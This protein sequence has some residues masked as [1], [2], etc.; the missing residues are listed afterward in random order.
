MVA[1]GLIGRFPL[2]TFGSVARDA[3][4]LD[5]V[6]MLLRTRS[7]AAVALFALLGT[8]GLSCFVPGQLLGADQK[9]CCRQMG[10][11]CGS[12]EMSSPQSCCKSPREQ[13]AQPYIGSAEHSQVARS[14]AVA[15]FLHIE[16]SPIALLAESALNLAQFHSPPLRLF[17][18]DSILRI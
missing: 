17:E 9:E 12:K 11:Q 2:P 15:T 5:S 1:W 13:S 16:P 6:G 8:P 4:R 18:T 3:G 14:A 7:C 10:S